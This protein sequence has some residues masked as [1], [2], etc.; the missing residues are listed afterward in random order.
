M[1]YTSKFSGEEIDSILNNVESKQDAIPDLE[2]I[3]SNAKNASDT[4]ARMVE[5]GYLFAGIATIGANPGIPEAKVFYIANGKGTYTN[6]GGLE[7]T[8]DEVVVL[9]WDSAWHKVSTGIASQEKLSELADIVVGAGQTI[10]V[11]DRTTQGTRI[12][13]FVECSGTVNVKLTLTEG[14][15]TTLWRIYGSTN[16]S[17]GSLLAN[18]LS[19]G[20][21]VEVTIPQANNGI[22]VFTLEN[23]QTGVGYDVY[24][25]QIQSPGDVGL[26]NKVNQ[27]EGK[28]DELESNLGTTA[29]NVATLTDNVTS[30]LVMTEEKAVTD[31]LFD[32][33]FGAVGFINEDGSINGN[34]SFVHTANFYPIP[35]GHER[36]LYIKSSDA[37]S[38]VCAVY[39]TDK[40]PVMN[41]PSGTSCLVSNNGLIKDEVAFF[42]AYARTD[43]STSANFYVGIKDFSGDYSY[44]M[45]RVVKSEDTEQLPEDWNKKPIFCIGDS[46]TE[47]DD[48]GKRYSD[49]LGDILSCNTTNVGIGG[50]R[51]SVRKQLVDNPSNQTDCF[52]HLDIANLVR[53]W[54]SND[55]SQV[56]KAATWLDANIANKYS[57]IISRYKNTDVTKCGVITIFAGTNDYMQGAS[58]GEISSTSRMDVNGAI[59]NII[60]DLLTANPKLRIVFFTPIVNYVDNIRDADH[61]CDNYVPASGGM[62]GVGKSKFCEDMEQSVKR[63]HVPCN[64]WYGTLGWNRANFETFF[65]N[66]SDSTHPF[67]GFE[68]LGRVMASF[69]KT[70]W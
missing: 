64:N 50:T 30:L 38:F 7:V 12:S 51:L 29:V 48:Q 57:A 40:N 1:Q 11:T 6:F 23:T 20:N 65:T 10:N 14:S 2:T 17:L 28:V 33:M 68:W 36:R 43:S 35:S 59:Y 21:E 58:M 67:G 16:G 70:L 47:F 69:L 42:K 5:S 26:I 46:I 8:E 63:N 61:W 56:D 41:N 15:T 62:Q 55:W 9:Y 66:P 24:D 13:K 32:K 54:V 31:N 37:S 52:A 34:T 3:R 53:C 19:L 4:I 44:E 49:F 60:N 22:V 18:N 25:I 27:L 45:Q 39:D